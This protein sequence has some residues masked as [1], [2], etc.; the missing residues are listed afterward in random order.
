MLTSHTTASPSRQSDRSNVQIIMPVL[1]AFKERNGLVVL[2]SML[3]VFA[4]AVKNSGAATAD[5]SSKVK[6]AAFGLK[7]ILDLYFV[8]ANGKYIADT[9]TY[10]NL[11]RQTDRSQV[12]PNIH[13]QIVVEFRA[14]ILPVVMELWDSNFVERVPDQTVKRLVDILKMVSLGENE[15][16]SMP[17]EKVN[18]IHF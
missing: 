15:L 9:H 18:K 1:L 3:R 12:V 5:E 2:N 10:F 6:V 17:K 16:Q 11:Q 7:K 14:A 8:L 4:N 13:S